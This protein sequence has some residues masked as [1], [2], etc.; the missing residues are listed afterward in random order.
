MATAHPTPG[1]RSADDPVVG[2]TGARFG[3]AAGRRRRAAAPVP[4]E[5][6]PTAHRHRAELPAVGQTGARF[7]HILR[8][9]RQA[10]RASSGDTGSGAARRDHAVSPPEPAP[11]A[12][13]SRTEA[14]ERV[15]QVKTSD[16]A[17]WDA[18][19]GP[20][21]LVRPY[22]WT[23]GRTASP[24]ELSLE[25]L[26]SV[27]GQ[28]IDPAAP[29]EHHTIVTLCEAP[30]SVAEV[31]ALL[32]VPLGVARVVLGDMAAAGTIVV[33]RAAGALDT[34]NGAPDLE[35]MRRVLCG[36]QRL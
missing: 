14:A 36:L 6:T 8:R 2:L 27:T 24:V 5:D 9:S 21:G 29:P 12:E 25:T 26:V 15:E 17:G 23:G 30:R 7:S 3:G 18:A 33:H 13:P 20:E 1:H 10:K 35:L 32:L 19:T 34:S 22:A 31:A 4:E 16:W 11:A 28:L